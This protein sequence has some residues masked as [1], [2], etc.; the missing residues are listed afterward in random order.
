MGSGCGGWAQPGSLV[1][2]VPWGDWP[3][4]LF[5]TGTDGGIYTTAGNP[6][7]GFPGGWAQVAG[8]SA[9]PGS[10][11]TAVPWGDWP[12]ALFVTGTDGGIYTTVGNPQDGFPGG[13]GRVGGG[14]A[15]LGSL[16]TAVPKGVKDQ[17]VFVTGLDGRIFVTEGNPQDGFGEPWKPL[18]GIKAP[19]GSPITATRGGEGIILFVTDING[20]VYTISGDIST[21]GDDVT[22]WQDWSPVVQPQGTAAPGA[23]VTVVGDLLFVTAPNGEVLFTTPA[24]PAV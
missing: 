21:D 23:P 8:G 3:F 5:V 11:V 14:L 17:Y 16:V 13:W 2:A 24:D 19:L 9:Q 18:D 15:K 10:P 12:F 22:T 20:G 6:Q 7:D 4:A 1:T